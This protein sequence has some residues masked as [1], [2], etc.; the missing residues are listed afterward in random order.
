MKGHIVTPETPSSG[1]TPV[2]VYYDDVPSTLNVTLAKLSGAQNL[3]SIRWVFLIAVTIDGNASKAAYE[4][5]K[6]QLDRVVSD[7]RVP[8][9]TDIMIIVPHPVLPFTLGVRLL[10]KVG[11]LYPSHAKAWL[12][13]WE[14]GRVDVEGDLTLARAIYGSYYAILSSL[15]LVEDQMWPFIGLSPG[16][17]PWGAHEVCKF[18]LRYE[19]FRLCFSGNFHCTLLLF[20]QDDYMGHVFWDQD[21][22]MY[23]GILM[24]HADLGR[25]LIGTRTRTM[26]A[27]AQNAKNYGYEGMKFPWE[28]AFSGWSLFSLCTV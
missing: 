15:P 7:Q 3:N 21:L 19:P 5:G 6:D 18:C 9:C 2:H 11:G 22:W 10:P 16:G 26:A 27:A 28:S 4:E 1:H 25:I 17:L 13:T 12:N 23:P 8:V 14:R 24:L 20:S